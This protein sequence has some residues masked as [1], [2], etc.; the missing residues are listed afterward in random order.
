[1]TCSQWYDNSDSGYCNPVYDALYK[2]QSS[3]TNVA[4]RRKIVYRMQKI[5]ANARP[6]IV[7][8]DLDVL[9]AW[10]PRWT[11]IIES[12]DGW[13]NSFSTDGQTAV[14]LSAGS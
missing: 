8:Q 5:V 6:Y 2:K 3:T 9:E 1:L 10:N 14:Q 11:D 13:F 12:P 7:L 4:K